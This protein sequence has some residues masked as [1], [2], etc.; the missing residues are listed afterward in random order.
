MHTPLRSAPPPAA[1]HVLF[2]VLLALAAGCARGQTTV[3]SSPE[4]VADAGDRSYI[5]DAQ[6]AASS[7]TAYEIIQRTRPEYLR[8]DQVVRTGLTTRSEPVLVANG[9][10]VGSLDD[11]RRM[12]ASSLTRIKHY[13]PDEA[14]RRFGMQFSSAVL[15]LTYRQR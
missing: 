12:P 3:A 15:E 5:G 7:E 13:G 10:Q 8:A 2:A 1:L 14:K 11:L 4:P 9:R 6:L